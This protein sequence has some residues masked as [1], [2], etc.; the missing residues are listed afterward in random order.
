MKNNYIIFNGKNSNEIEGLIIQE[1]PEIT[2]PK[3]RTNNVVIDGRDGDIVEEL[4][5]ASYTKQLSIGLNTKADIDE[6]M[7]FFTG[8]G[9]VIFSN[10]PDKVYD[11]LAD[12]KVD[13]KR[14]VKFRQ[15]T[16]K[17]HVQPFKY[18]VDEAPLY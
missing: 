17:F 16:V 11:V 5:Y 3:L 13:Y 14:L 2:K 18:L 15:A 4:G 1:L 10:E 9:K 8:K 12:D 7:N 6:V